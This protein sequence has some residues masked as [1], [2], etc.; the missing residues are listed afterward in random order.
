MKA[1][2]NEVE[3]KETR[4]G[5]L[6]SMFV[7]TEMETKRKREAIYSVGMETRWKRIGN[8]G[9]RFSFPAYRQ[10]MGNETAK[11]GPERGVPLPETRA[12]RWKRS[13]SIHPRATF[14][15]CA[16]FV[17]CRRRL[18]NRL[19]KGCSLCSLCPQETNH[20]HKYE[21]IETNPPWKFRH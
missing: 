1:G 11:T 20:A 13:A 19:H 15:L 9:S 3:T 6:V 16:L 5:I 10:E 17:P 4:M 21:H 7:E 14:P 8:G 12:M 18:R 2:G